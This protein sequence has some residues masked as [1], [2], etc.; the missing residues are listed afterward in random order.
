[1]EEIRRN[2]EFKAPLERVWA[3]LTEPDLI[4]RWLMPNTFEPELDRPFTM[5]CPPG[6]GS[7]RPIESV[8]T[9]LEPPDGKRARLAYS[10]EIDQPLIKTL[11]EIELHEVG[12]V[13][14]LELVHSGWGELSPRDAYVGERHETGWDHLLGTALRDL[15]ERF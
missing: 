4:A 10:W 7:G 2:I 6:I 9:R 8:V 12:N 5:D 15:L 3:C 1:M 14:R 11:V 13:T